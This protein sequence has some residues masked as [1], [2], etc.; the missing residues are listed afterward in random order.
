MRY[1]TPMFAALVALTLMSPARAEES[2]ANSP[3]L[4]PA[5]SFEIAQRADRR[6]REERDQEARDQEARDREQDRLEREGAREREET[7]RDRAEQR[8]ERAEARHDREFIPPRARAWIGV[9]A[10]AGVSSIKVACSGAAP[11]VYDCDR[12]GDLGTYSANITIT[13]PYT[14]LRVR[15]VRQQDKGDDLHTPYEEAVLI[16]SRF[17]TSNWY[18]LAGVGRIQHI[19]D[20]HPDDAHGFAWEILFAPSTA[21]AT[22]LELSF[23]GELGEDVDYVGVNLGLRFGMLR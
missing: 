2:Q 7:R 19:D 6:N 15:G 17:G 23:Q 11:H 14:A 1:S 13:G 22:G 5:T 20:D 12:S 18:G 3:A 8:R 9:G 21:S 10:G 16:G 4:A